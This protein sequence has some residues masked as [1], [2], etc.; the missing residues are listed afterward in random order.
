[1]KRIVFTAALGAALGLST[2]AP[3]A[4]AQHEEVTQGHG[5]HSSE[6]AGDRAGVAEAEADAKH[7]GAGTAEHH[8]APAPINWLDFS[9]KEQPPYAAMFLNFVLLIAMYVWLGKK[10]ISE[11]L[12]SRRAGVAKEIEEAQ[13]MRQEAEARALVYQKKL[14]HLEEELKETRASL[15]EAGKGDRDRIVREAEE[16]AARME[17]D[18][19][20]LIEQ[21]MKQLRVDL[22]REAVG[23]AVATAEELLKKRVTPVDQE[24]LAEDYLAELTA[25]NKPAPGSMPPSG[26]PSGS[27]A[28][29][30]APQGG[31]S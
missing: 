1:M 15:V 4:S 18:A 20:F 7:E 10:P 19:L 12:K 9:N 31:Q 5:A 22:M 16:K 21:E 14:E 13:R 8:G 6:H 30:V 27:F 24:R 3:L 2:L 17:K 25:K 11:A 26:R 23:V 28:S 29:P